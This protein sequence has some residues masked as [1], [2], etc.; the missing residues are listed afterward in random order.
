MYVPLDVQGAAGGREVR[1]NFDLV[2]REKLVSRQDLRNIQRKLERLT[3]I[4]HEDDATSVHLMVEALRKETHDPVVLYKRYGVVDLDL[5]KDRFQLV[6]QTAWQQEMMLRYGGELLLVDATHKTAAK[7]S[8][9]KLV[10]AVVV[11]NDGEGKD[12][13]P[14]SIK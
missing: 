3:Q 11:D 10:T 13:Q 9:V 4:C 6:L 2:T 14:K 7:Y 8:D 5:P 12:L 1:D